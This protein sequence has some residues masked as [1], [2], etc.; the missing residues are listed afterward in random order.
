MSD[1]AIEREGDTWTLVLDRPDKANALSAALVD[2]LADAVADAAARGARVLVFRGR[3]RNFSAG[4]D[5]TGVEEQG[6]AELLQRFVRI[7]L[8]LQAIA[9]SPCHTV[10]LAHGR[11]FGAGVDIIAAC[12]W[13]FASAEAT[14]RMPGLAFGLVLG[15]SRF[16]SI[17]GRETAREILA[18]LLTF[19]ARRAHE[20]GFLR[21]VAGEESW[22][23]RVAEAASE[24][25]LP[26]TGHSL[27][28]GALP[29]GAPDT[30][31]ANLVRSAAAPGIKQRI[32]AYLAGQERARA[33]AARKA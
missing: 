29:A 15:V 5:F 16:A 12:R 11:N 28:E 24:A 14:F 26:G 25:M 21:A 4:F 10:A 32:A 7:E 2:A 8:L 31:L 20:I 27:L 6:E 19:D 9:A 23:A 3:G 18:G 17:V 13:R 22:P 30:D 1:L 33:V